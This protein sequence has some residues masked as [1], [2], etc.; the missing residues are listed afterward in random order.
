MRG[1]GIQ[2]VGVDHERHWALANECFD[3][4][5]RRFVLAEARA[6]HDRLASAGQLQGA[7]DTARRKTA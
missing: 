6:K 1:E 2:P 7:F 3:E 4:G 5:S